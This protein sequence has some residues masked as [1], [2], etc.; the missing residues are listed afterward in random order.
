[1]ANN[2]RTAGE[3]L[4]SYLKAQGS[5]PT[6]PVREKWQKNSRTLCHK[7]PLINCNLTAGKLKK[8]VLLGVNNKL[9]KEHINQKC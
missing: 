9:L 3:H 5:S 7:C 6:S 1:M 2:G 4:P 8:I